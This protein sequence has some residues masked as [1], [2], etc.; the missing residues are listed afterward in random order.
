M[1]NPNLSGARSA[2]VVAP[3]DAKRRL[4]YGVPFRLFNGF[5]VLLAAT[6]LLLFG[7]AAHANE[8]EKVILA[9]GDSLTAGYGLSK[10]DSF[11]T[12]LET[13]LSENGHKVRVINAGVSGDTSAGG[14]SRLD[15]LLSEKPDLLLLEL[16]A[17]DGLR[18]LAPTETKTNLAKIIKKAKAANI[19]VLLAGMLAPPNMGRDY[20]ADFNAIYPELAKQYDVVFYPFFLE[21]VAGDPTLNQGDGM[22]PTA[23]GVSIIVD[24]LLPYVERALQ[25]KG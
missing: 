9:L 19:P 1:I 25:R 15:W 7:P 8:S 3:L 10:Q 6:I 21:G 12:Q 14:L 2:T 23:E 11:P 4:A 5:A 20:G 18:A 24:R 13:A 22:H 17:N 16:G